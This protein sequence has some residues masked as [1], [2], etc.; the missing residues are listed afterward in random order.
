MTGAGLRL[1]PRPG[2]VIDRSAPLS[3]TWNGRRYDG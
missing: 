2:E 3:F 1:G